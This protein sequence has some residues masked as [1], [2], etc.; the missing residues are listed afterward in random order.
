MVAPRPRKGMNRFAQGAMKLASRRSNPMQDS[1]C[2][3]LVSVMMGVSL[4]GV[5]FD[6]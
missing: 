5:F 4:C 3:D 1:M 2:P 6:E